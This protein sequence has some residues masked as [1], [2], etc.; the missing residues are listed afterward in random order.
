MSNVTKLRPAEDPDEVLTA[1]MG[2]YEQVLILGWNK[3]GNMDVRATLGLEA[4]ECVY[5]MKLFEAAI[6]S[7]A[8]E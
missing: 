4:A 3:Q 6:L 2:Q 7:E 5:L 8:L 1:A